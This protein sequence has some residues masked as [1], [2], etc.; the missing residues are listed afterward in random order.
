MGDEK[1]DQ[2]V[3]I[4]FKGRANWVRGGL[5]GRLLRVRIASC[6]LLSLFRYYFDD[7]PVQ[8][9]VKSHDES[10]VPGG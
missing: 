3:L 6:G 4:S 7:L 10:S 5:Y 2:L 1:H 8:Y 9:T